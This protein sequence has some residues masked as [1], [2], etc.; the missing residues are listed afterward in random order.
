MLAAVLGDGIGADDREERDED[1]QTVA[2][3]AEQHSSHTRRNEQQ[4]ERLGCGAEEDAPE[5]RR[6][7]SDDRIRSIARPTAFRLVGGETGRGIDPEPGGHAR[8]RLRV[9]VRRELEP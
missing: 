4:D 3:L 9:A 6:V 7:R 2:D 8:H 1:E 5:A